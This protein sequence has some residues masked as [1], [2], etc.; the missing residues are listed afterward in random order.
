MSIVLELKRRNVFRVAIAYVIIAWL[1]LQ[2]GDTLGPALRLPEAVNTALAFFLILGFPLAVFFAWAYELTPEG[3]KKEKDVGR[4]QSITHVTGRKLDYFIIGVLVLALSYFAYDKFVLVPSRDAELVQAATEQAAASDR[5]ETADK[6]IAVLAFAD[7]SP[8]GDQEYFSDGISEEL[9]NVLSKIPG[10]RVVARTSSFQFKGENRN[11]IDIGEQLNTTFVLE[12]SVRK[13]GLQ[14]RITAQLIDARSGFHLWSESY[15]RELDD[16]FAVQ[17]EISAAILMALKERLGLQVEM[18]SRVTPPAN[19]EAHDAYLRGRYLVVQRTPSTV[20]GAVREFEKAI[21]VDPDYALAHAELAMALLLRTLFGDGLSLSDT[22]ASADFHAQRALAL[23]PTLAEAHAATGYV[24]WTNSILT[25]SKFDEGLAHFRQAIHINPNY[26]T[27]YTWM[28]GLLGDYLGRYKEAFAA[29]E[30]A[31]QLDPLSIQGSH[32]YILALMERNRLDEADRE[33]EKLA[34]IA[35]GFYANM[36]GLRT[37]VGGKWT[38]AILG[39]LDALQIDTEHPLWCQ[40][41]ILE[42][43]ILG[44]EEEVL[45]FEA[46]PDYIEVQVRSRMGKTEDAVAIAEARLAR[47]PTS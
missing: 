22:T 45:A 11:I 7:L 8:E 44:L 9:L 36:R 2:I 37:S 28:G 15:D 24:L 13:A 38:N 46:I 29:A 23:D 14:V 20:D 18:A 42:F 33:L 16:I 34:S 27:V 6:S 43:A 26:S 3:I 4:S 21:A 1:I 25:H 32:F 10:L 47:V 5:R 12:G 31:L 40:E 19:N 35:P 41:L 39:N 17:E 30:T